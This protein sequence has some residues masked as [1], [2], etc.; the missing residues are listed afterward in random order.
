M[1]ASESS[2]RRKKYPHAI[3]S[4]PV[5]DRPREKLLMKGPESLSNAEL[6]A[7]FL[8]VGVEG[9]SA[10]ALAQEL[11]S[12]FGSLRELYAAPLEE[13]EHVLGMGRAKI[14]QFKAVTEL[15]KRYLAE[16]FQNRPYV[17]SSGDILKLLYQEM[18]DL[19]QEVFK[20]LLLNGQNHV[21]KIEEISRGT[22]TTAQIYPREVVKV[23]LRNSAA[24][25]VFVHNHPSGVAQPSAD[26]KKITRDLVLACR[27]MGIKVHDHIII[28]DNDK[29]SFADAG[30]IEQY[31]KDFNS[32]NAP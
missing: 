24:A 17:E 22:L 4:W 8:R 21:L 5:E 12:R 2:R 25:L 7:I 3:V 28:G 30:I 6:L 18:R 31:D 10:L 26:D 13:L 1:S 32:R 29:F 9:K 23:A 11:L 27:L 15:S 20:V 14:A 16:G 19:D